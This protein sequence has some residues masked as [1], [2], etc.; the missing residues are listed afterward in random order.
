[1]YDNNGVFHHAGG[2][3]DA[4]LVA[5]CVTRTERLTRRL[6]VLVCLDLW[7]QCYFDRPRER[8]EAPAADAA[9]APQ[10]PAA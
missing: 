3:A 2:V 7:A 8:L 5:D 10:V 9:S 1:M 4:A 6:W